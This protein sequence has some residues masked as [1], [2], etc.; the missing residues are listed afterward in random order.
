MAN[1]ANWPTWQLANGGQAEPCLPPSQR[2]LCTHQKVSDGEV[3][4]LRNYVKTD[5]TFKR[6]GQEQLHCGH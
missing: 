3:A 5:M 1:F 6:S 2:T 4:V